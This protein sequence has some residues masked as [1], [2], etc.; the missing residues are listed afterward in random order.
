MFLY[1]LRIFLTIVIVALIA[2]GIVSLI[3]V[4]DYEERVNIYNAQVTAA[5]DRAIQN[6]VYDATR[7]I[8][9]P[10]NRYQLL[11]LDADS[12]LQLL[13][14]EYNTTLELIQIVNGLAEDV[15]QGNG[16]TIVIPIGVSDLE[17]MRMVESHRA[18]PGDTLES[19][20]IAR[21]ISE[22]LLEED[23]PVLAQRGVRPGD[24]VFIGLE[25]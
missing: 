9:A 21:G 22:Q 1:R 23:N 12:D 14:Q 16:V 13:A 7:T 10:M 4:R 15:R 19:I 17:P 18:L 20:A 5:I 8:E 11:T 25:L 6:A 2:V 24:I 3:L